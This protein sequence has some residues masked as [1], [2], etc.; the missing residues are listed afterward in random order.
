MTSTIKVD[1]ISEKTSGNGVAID[2]LGIK[3]GKVTNL[4]NA[5]LSAADLGTGIHIKS[6]DSGASVESAAGQL[7]VEGDGHSGLS[8]LSGNAHTGNINFGDDG[9]A[10]IGFIQYNHSGNSLSF[11][12]NASTYFFIDDSGRLGIGTTSPGSFNSQ[13]QNLVIGSGSGDAGMTIYSGSGSGDSGNIFFADGTSDPDFIRGGITYKHDDNSLIFRV[14][15]S[16]TVTLD[17]SHNMIFDNSGSGVYLGV[18]SA[19]ASNLLDDYEVG[20]FTPT[21]ATT[22]TNFSSI[23]Y[24]TQTGEYVKVGDLVIAHA[25]VTL[26]SLTAGSPTGNAVVSGLPFTSKDTTDMASSIGFVSNINFDISSFGTID[27]GATTSA[28]NT[29]VSLTRTRNSGTADGVPHQA[30]TSSSTDINLVAIYKTA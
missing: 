11:G 9:D 27:V 28:N 2:S 14:D 5:T 4:M 19:A 20:T 30:V 8:I 10:N 15:D 6:A 13:A 26:N 18:T 24:A 29:R 1:T 3:D 23:G 25:R 7:V 16:P 21:L 17:S 12:T 22:G